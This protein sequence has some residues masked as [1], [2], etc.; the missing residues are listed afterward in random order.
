MKNTKEIN[1]KL[2]EIL[3]ELVKDFGFCVDPNCADCAPY[4]KARDFIK[5]IEGK[6]DKDNR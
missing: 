1:T 4:H 6:Y 5:E 3:K 2:L